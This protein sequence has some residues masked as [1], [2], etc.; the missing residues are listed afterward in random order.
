MSLGVILHYLLAFDEFYRFLIIY[1]PALHLFWLLS[2]HEALK[3][4]LSVLISCSYCFYSF[5]CVK[6]LC[7][8]LLSAFNLLKKPVDHLRKLVDFNFCLIICVCTS[9]WKFSFLNNCP[10]VLNVLKL[11]KINIVSTRY[12]KKN[13][14]KLPSIARSLLRRSQSREA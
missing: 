7:V 3:A 11:K 14:E 10:L 1:P 4:M 12:L 2:I 9:W 5:F 8:R 6:I 13:V